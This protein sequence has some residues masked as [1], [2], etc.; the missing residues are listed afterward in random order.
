MESRPWQRHYDY[1][2]PVTIR[3]PRIPLHELLSIPANSFPDKAALNFYGTEMTFW[4]LRHFVLR[5]ANALA[6]L[7]LKKGDRVGLN[8]PNCPQYLI[9]NYAAI[10][11]GAIVVN[12]NPMYTT[13]ELRHAVD[14]TGMTTLF[15]FDMVLPNIRALCQEADI[16]RVIV[17]RPSDF[18]KGVPCST[19]QSLELEPKWHH[20]S[21]LLDGCTETRRP[22]VQVNPEDPC[23]I[24]FTGGT[25]GL[26][27]AAVLTHAN[28]VAATFQCAL[29][30]SSTTQ[31]TPPER[32]SVLAVLPFF[33]VYGNIVVMNWAMLNCATQI[34]I[35]RFQ[36]DEIMGILA[37]FREIT[38][39]PAVP[40]MITALI[41]HPK[42][43]ELDLGRK[44]GLLNSG[45]A[46]MPLDLIEQVK[47]MGLPFSEGW[48]MSETTSLGTG[49][50][51]LGMK[52]TGSI[53]IPFPDADIKIVNVENGVDEVK[54]GE[55]GELL[56][57]SPVVMKEYY[58]D[59]AE[60]AGQIK[61]GWLSTGDIV[62]RD[63]D[64]YIFIVDRKKD[65]VIAGGFNIYPR[66]IDEVLYQ[67]PKVLEAVS[68]G[69]RDDYRGETLKAYVVLKPGETA[70]GEDIIAFCKQKLA[71]YKV[72]KLVQFRDSLPKSAV[73][74][75]LRKILRAE[76]EA[77]QKV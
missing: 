41:N 27:K 12:L 66:E 31:L 67:H 49:N 7:G 74:K 25:T 76:E 46:P 24:Q 53:G 43:T 34:L 32:R 3:Y 9:A 59:P 33:H 72:P 73:G 47:D 20:F 5:M 39:F 69:I 1:N 70:T 42:V 58:D 4:Q 52:K 38:F 54:P 64:D 50:P 14:K 10:S 35:P 48:G 60:T 6:K 8:L 37:N 15:T 63:E 55:P 68:V 62:V 19:K 61:D 23:M 2:V 26:P 40:T 45:G 44:L 51:L 57:R 21:E 29:W 56:I 22:R 71:T 18:I 77:N 75:V 30:G 17:T 16:A 28:L 11:L 65:M 36:I 13:P